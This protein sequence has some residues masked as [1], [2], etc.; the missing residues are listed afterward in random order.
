MP[1]LLARAFI[2]SLT[3]LS[4]LCRSLDPRFRDQA[5]YDLA[6]RELQIVA[7]R[8]LDRTEEMTFTETERTVVNRRV[9]G[10]LESAKIAPSAPTQRNILPLWG[11]KP[12]A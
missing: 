12:I 4:V 1:S 11:H 6:A 5:H 8:R 10:L 3:L 9:E 7:V 2:H